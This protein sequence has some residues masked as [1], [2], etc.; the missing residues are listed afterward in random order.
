MDHSFKIKSII[1]MVLL[2]TS[3]LRSQAAGIGGGPNAFYKLPLTARE[4]SLGGAGIAISR[5]PFSAFWNPAL[6]VDTEHRNS[7]GININW[8][9]NE[10]LLSDKLLIGGLSHQ[11]K[12]EPIF[13]SAL[14]MHKKVEGII[15]TELPYDEIEITGGES[16]LTE[17]LLIMTLAGKFRSGSAGF[18]WRPSTSRLDKITWSSWKNL[19]I[20]FLVSEDKYDYGFVIKL[21]SDSLNTDLSFGTGGVIKLPLGENQVNATADLKGGQNNFPEFAVGGEYEK[22]KVQ[23]RGGMNFGF[24]NGKFDLNQMQQRFVSIGGSI[25]VET[26]SVDLSWTIPVSSSD[27]GEYMRFVDIPLKLSL[28]WRK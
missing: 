13:F 9:S 27:I 5:G 24:P 26:I 4:A 18:S 3:L 12:D 7:V 25:Q 15:N 21:D 11:Y 2:M 10:I 28:I 14:W 8:S 16:G 19:D 22:D 6:I 1:L 20:G 23:I 17:N